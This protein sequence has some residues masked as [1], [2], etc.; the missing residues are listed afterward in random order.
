MSNKLGT[1]ILVVC[2]TYVPAQAQ[3]PLGGNTTPPAFQ[4]S[5]AHMEA[6]NRHRRIVHHHDAGANTHFLKDI[7]PER[8]DEVVQYLVSPLDA[9][10][11][12]IDSV[13]YDW[14]TGNQAN[15]PST[16]LPLL[17]HGPY[18]GW[19]KSGVDI[20]GLVQE[21]AQQRGREVFF[22]YRVNGGDHAFGW[23]LLPMKKDHPQWTHDPYRG[24]GYKTPHIFWNFAF[25]GVRDY[26]V[27]IIRELA[28]NYDF[29]GISIDF[30]R[31]PNSFPI[32]TQWE[33]RDHL[34]QFMRQVR[35]MMLE[36][37][38]QRGRPI[39]LAA[40]VPESIVGCHFDGIDIESWTRENLL[41]I[42]ALGGRIH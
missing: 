19:L 31:G 3:Q 35:Q 28:E 23:R 30:A 18:P 34:T 22:S 42:L 27:K 37:E 16:V 20:V 33:H 15:Y 7:G 36:V 29:D 1:V 12:Q 6:V 21:A 5:S 2:C 10:A 26:K 9:E 25:Q 24:L 32:G 39:L 40:R 14:T 4:L 13:W 17:N 38:R 41:D 8:I 11:N